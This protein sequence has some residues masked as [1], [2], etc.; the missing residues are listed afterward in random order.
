MA[1][2]LRD[3]EAAIVRVLNPR[4]RIVGAGFLVGDREVVSC[5]HVVDRALGPPSDSDQ[6]Q[7]QEVRLD[8]PMVAPGRAVAAR[9]AVWQPPLGDG[10]GDVAGLQLREPPPAG[11]RAVRLINGD[12][13]WDHRFRV[14]GFPAEHGDGVWATGRLRGRQ[15]TGWVQMDGVTSTGY[16][17]EQGFSGAAVWDEELDAVVG[18]A[19]AAERRPDVRVAYLIPTG[20]LVETWPDL[21]DQMLPPCPYLGLLAFQ[22]QDA[23]RF[24]GRAELAAKLVDQLERQA[25]VAVVGP[26]GSGKSSLVFAGAV[27][28]LRRRWEG[29]VVASLRP[30]RGASAQ[31]ALAA[32]LLPL[33]EPAMTE[34]DRLLEVPKLAA[35]LDQG[36]LLPVTERALQQ[37]RARRLLLIVDQAEEPSC[38]CRPRRPSG[39]VPGRP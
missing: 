1:T 37:A 14:L 26:S 25:L 3:L 24:F 33:L 35:A 16:P 30:A 32:A 8:F 2:T 39:D 21:A 5:A 4:G 23:T 12:E 17:I 38:W 28:E 7:D 11:V 31:T 18:M 10:S 13:L 36:G 19:V 27:P 20:T 22:E 29:W 6:G 9:V 15:A 34:A